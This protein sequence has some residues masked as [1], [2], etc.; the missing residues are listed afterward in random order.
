MLKW[1]LIYVT[2]R[3]VIGGNPDLIKPGQQLL[4][5]YLPKL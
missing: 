3:D 2:N 5:P 1:S 4:I